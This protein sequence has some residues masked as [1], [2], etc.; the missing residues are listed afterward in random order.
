VAA[1]TI[2]GTNVNVAQAAI[3][4]NRNG[5]YYNTD[6]RGADMLRQAVNEGI[7]GLCGGTLRRNSR[8][9]IQLANSTVTGRKYGYQ[10]GVTTKPVPVH[11]F[12]Q[13]FQRG[14]QGRLE[15]ADTR[16]ATTATTNTA[17][18]TVVL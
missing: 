17:R 1:I 4:S 2:V 12:Q 18:T 13:G 14:Y 8:R 9:N 16:M 15:T 5:G 7:A 3:A 6:N 10:T 11:Y